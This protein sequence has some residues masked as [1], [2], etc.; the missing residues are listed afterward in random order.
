MNITLYSLKQNRKLVTKDLSSVTSLTITGDFRRSVDLINPVIEVSDVNYLTLLTYNYVYIENLRRYYFIENITF[1]DNS[2]IELS[3]HED[4]LNSFSSYIL[5]SYGFVERSYSNFDST[6]L[7]DNL[8]P[9]K[10]DDYILETKCSES[11]WDGASI[12]KWNP[13]ISSNSYIFVIYFVTTKSVY[14]TL[15][16]IYSPEDNL[17]LPGYSS[18]FNGDNLNTTAIITNKDGLESFCS[19]MLNHSDNAKSVLGIYIMP[20]EP[21]HDSTALTDIYMGKEHL[22]ISG[23]GDEIKG[24]FYNYK[25]NYNVLADFSLKD[26]VYLPTSHYSWLNYNSKFQLWIPFVGWI[27]IEYSQVK[28]DR[29]QLCYLIKACTGKAIISL[30]DITTNQL[31]YTSTANIGTELILPNS[32]AETLKTQTIQDSITNAI[33]VVAGT[34]SVIAGV[35]GAIPTGGLSTT[36]VIGGVTSIASGVASEGKT[37]Q[38]ALTKSQTTSNGS[39]NAS[40]DFMTLPLEPR[41]RSM[42]KQ[43]IYKNNTESYECYRKRYGLPCQ[44]V[45][46][47][48]SLTGYALITDLQIND[49]VGTSTELQEIQDLMKTGVYITDITV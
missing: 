16:D 17:I 37:I 27:D 40:S 8:L 41:I 36:A 46:K 30:T 21:K 26:D 3:L 32:N 45:I 19:W 12:T 42:M 15:D 25:D 4:V 43:P 18:I 13:L 47:L 11:T 1:L 22:T 34:A 9:I 49:F 14:G 31:I 7:T 10:I 24:T 35:A 5:L 23:S 33:K 20:F 44:Q 6:S 48:S 38:N 29:L 2:I 28:K 39:V